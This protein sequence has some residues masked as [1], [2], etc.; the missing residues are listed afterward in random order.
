MAKKFVEDTMENLFSTITIDLILC[1]KKMC[2]SHRREQG[3]I[4]DVIDFNGLKLLIVD[5]WPGTYGFAQ[6]R[7]YKLEGFDTQKEYREYMEE[8]FKKI[9]NNDILYHHFFNIKDEEFLDDLK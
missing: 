9:R 2:F 1:R 6:Q 3:K 5:I 8:H 7:L 4:G